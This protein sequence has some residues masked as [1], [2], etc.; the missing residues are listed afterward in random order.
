[1]NGDA[2]SFTS[3]FPGSTL[4]LAGIST[5]GDFNPLGVNFSASDT[6]NVSGSTFVVFSPTTDGIGLGTSTFVIDAPGAT[7]GTIGVAFS[8][9]NTL[10]NATVQG[11][12]A[13]SG[14]GT[15]GSIPFEFST[16][17][18]LLL[19]GGIFGLKK[20]IQYLKSRKNKDSDS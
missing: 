15:S 12:V 17:P 14:G 13:A 20:G 9:G 4:S 6:F 7:L 2:L 10:D 5:G 8:G 1:V 19:L 3:L 18:G 11:P 16:T